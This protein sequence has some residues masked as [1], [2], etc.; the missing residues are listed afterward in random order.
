MVFPLS[1]PL[2]DLWPF[3]CLFVFSCVVFRSLVGLLILKLLC[4]KKV[5]ASGMA[6]IPPLAVAW[7]WAWKMHVWVSNSQLYLFPVPR[8]DWKLFSLHSLIWL[9]QFSLVIWPKKT[10]KLPKR[11]RLL[12]VYWTELVYRGSSEPL[13]LPSCPVLR[14]ERKRIIHP[15]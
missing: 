15:P 4:K 2:S 11:S 3:V 1:L 5:L 8:L 7:C 10:Q 6:C 9:S 14:R 13:D 12:Q